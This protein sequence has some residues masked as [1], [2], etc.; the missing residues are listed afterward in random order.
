MSNLSDIEE[1]IMQ[2]FSKLFTQYLGPT[3]YN[4]F[5]MGINRARQRL[6]LYP[7][8]AL[9]NP[10]SPA[11][12]LT[13]LL[14]RKEKAAWSQGGSRAEIEMMDIEMYQ[15]RGPAAKRSTAI[16]PKISLR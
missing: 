6:L 7:K 15:A 10:R 8:V 11:P 14:R 1:R 13:T 12:P 16:S 3:C 9:T 2:R 5:V 4:T